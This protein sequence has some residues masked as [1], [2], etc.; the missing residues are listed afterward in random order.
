LSEQI[1]TMNRQSPDRTRT[2][3][4]AAGDTLPALAF[5]A[6]G[7]DALWRY[8]ADANPRLITDPA[9]IEAGMVLQIPRIE[10]PTLIVPPARVA[11]S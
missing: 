7:D 5:R 11:T 10:D 8:I 6:Y 9:V 4:V 2:V 1:G 3:V